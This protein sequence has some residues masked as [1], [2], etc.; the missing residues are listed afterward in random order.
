MMCTTQHSTALLQDHLELYRQMWVLRLLDMAFEESRIDGLID[1]PGQAAFG[2]EAVAVGTTAALRPGDILNTT[3]P[4]FRHARRAGLALPLALAIA[5]TI[6][7]ALGAS[8]EP[9]VGWKQGLSS[10]PTALEQS[11]VYAVGDAHTQQMAGKGEVTLCAIGIRDANSA[12][13]TAAAKVAVSWRLPIVFVVENTRS[14][15]KDNNH[16]MA[17]LSVDGSDVEA[18]RGAVADAVQ[19]SSTGRVPILVEAVIHRTNDVT[20]ADPLIVA[21]QR[22]IDAGVCAGHLYEVERRARHLVA[23]AESFATAMLRAEE[24]APTRQPEPWSAA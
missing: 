22:L 7:P 12:E 3:I 21:R 24:P 16:G 1:G 17:V 20:G 4:R 14:A 13:F 6:D 23:E 11:T 2:R 19:R 10:L 8:A 18:V 15:I 5:Q 9:I